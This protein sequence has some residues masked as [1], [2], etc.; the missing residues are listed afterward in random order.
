[1]LP[2]AHIN[3][4]INPNSTL[5]QELNIVGGWMYYPYVNVPSRGLLRA[6]MGSFEDAR[7]DFLL[8]TE[9]APHNAGMLINLGLMHANLKEYEPALEVFNRAIDLDALSAKAIYWRGMVHM[10]LRNY[11]K[12][13]EDMKLAASH[14]W[15]Q[16]QIPEFC[17]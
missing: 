13:C 14:G 16:E 5:Y 6:T 1:V 4:V 12:A 11:N 9:L 2:Y 7:D 8:A 17:K 10:Q 15:P 3:V